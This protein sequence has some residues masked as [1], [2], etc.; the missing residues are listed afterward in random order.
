[1]DKLCVWE[2]AVT[3]EGAKVPKDSIDNNNNNN[4]SRVEYKVQTTQQC[5]RSIIHTKTSSNR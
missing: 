2:S 3:N 1:M 4:N 5:D